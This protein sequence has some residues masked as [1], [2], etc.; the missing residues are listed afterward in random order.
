MVSGSR[1]PVECDTSIDS[2]N[3]D[4]L[5]CRFGRASKKIEIRRHSKVCKGVAVRAPRSSFDWDELKLAVGQRRQRTGLLLWPSHNKERTA[6]NNV[7]M[8]ELA[9]VSRT[10]QL[11]P[12]PLRTRTQENMVTFWAKETQNIRSYTLAWRLGCAGTSSL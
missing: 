9:I 3:G 1:R 2:L 6:L 7:N 12:V 5:A 4:K 8:R 10:T 11:A